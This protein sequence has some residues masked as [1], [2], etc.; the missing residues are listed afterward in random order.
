MKNIKL[1]LLI[2]LCSIGLIY[3]CS[4]DLSELNIDPDVS[5]TARPQE[6][7]TAAEG[8]LS[9]MVDGQYNIT[10]FMWAQYWTWGPGVAIGNVERY[11]LD[12]ADFNNVWGH[13]YSNA[14]TDLK[15]I[16]ELESIRHTGVAK[17]LQAYIYQ[18]LVDHFGD[19]PFSEALRGETRDGAIFSPTFDDDQA[20]YAALPALIDE[21]IEDLTASSTVEIGSEDLIFQGNV[22]SWIRF[23]NSLKLRILMRQSDVVDVSAQVRD[24]I[25]NG[26]FIETANDIAKIT[27]SG[28]V[29][30]ENPMYARM[31]AGV[32]N[33]YVA[34]GTSVD[35]LTETG[36]PRLSIL[37]APAANSGNIVSIPQG[38]IDLEP[39]TASVGDYS[40][41]S[42]VLY[43]NNN[44]VIFMSHWE[45]WF[46][47]AEAALKFNT[48]DNSTTAFE[49]AVASHF[50]YVGA[51]RA[52]S[53]IAGLNYDGA[54]NVDK[55]NL[56][57]VQKW[58]SMNGLQDDEGWI[59]TRR[60]DTP[61]NPIFSQEIFETPVI[62]SLPAGVFPS[63]WL[64]PA[65]ELS[66]NQNS[67]GQRSSVT[68]KVFWDK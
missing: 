49:N 42:S 28:A 61:D 43:A 27:F 34:S 45:T 5:P 55:L 65:N 37:Y 3:S 54:S 31:E 2:V 38:S 41:M 33:F 35:Y 58:I 59:E 50:A 32:K 10:S 6:L 68:D 7:L 64:Y 18:G 66:L 51:E 19:V 13:A 9:W 63:I 4:D 11:V 36:D 53:F 44:P 24:L 39:F 26:S 60:F 23:A 15:A 12:G 21:G 8:Y 17:I 30:G 62:S 16:T 1:Y 20:I 40:Q 22:Q 48:A 14:L 29:G 67:P 47:R 25:A 56:I 52:D 57:A 46:L